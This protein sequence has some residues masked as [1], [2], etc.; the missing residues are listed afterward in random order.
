MALENNVFE[1]A[2]I[3]DVDLLSRPWSAAPWSPCALM[4]WL[5]NQTARK[6]LTPKLLG[7]H[8]Y[9]LKSSEVMKGGEGCNQLFTGFYYNYLLPLGRLT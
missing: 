7:C 6:Y 4:S 1:L 3:L 2:N 9:I 8:G 5:R